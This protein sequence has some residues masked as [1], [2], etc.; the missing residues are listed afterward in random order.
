MPGGFGSWWWSLELSVAPVSGSRSREA[1]PQQLLANFFTVRSVDV[2][3]R[4]VRWC[5]VHRA[6]N[7]A[8]NALR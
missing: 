4:P 2:D 1:L 8:R 5:L 3:E 6:V 7:T